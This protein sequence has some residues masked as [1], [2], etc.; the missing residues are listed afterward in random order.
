MRSVFNRGFEECW[1]GIW[2]LD[3]VYG[4]LENLKNVKIFGVEMLNLLVIEDIRYFNIS[5]FEIISWVILV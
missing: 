5:V 3:S 1:Y 4:G 2:C